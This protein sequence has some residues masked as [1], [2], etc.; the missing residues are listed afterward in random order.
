MQQGLEP[1]PRGD[2]LERLHQQHLMIAGDVA[3]LEQWSDL[4][5][6]GRHLV[7][8][9]LDRHAQPVELLLGL[10]HERQHPGGNGAEVVILELLSLGRLGPEERA[11]AGQQIGTPIVELPVHQEVLLLGA[12]G[13]NDARD[14]LVGAEDAEY[15]KRLLGKRLDRAQQRDLGVQGLTGPGH[16]CSRDAE[17]NVVL[18]PH[19]KGRA[20]GVPGGVAP[21]LERG[22]ES[23]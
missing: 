23:A 4:V 2:P 11:L 17:R 15:P 21:R 22:P 10:G 3:R 6:A 5:L 9:G 1:V 19:Q 18:S 14:T 20:G 7:V 12:D 13:G 16:E 8:P